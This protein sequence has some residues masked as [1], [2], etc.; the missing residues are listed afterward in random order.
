MAITPPSKDSRL[1]KG[2]SYLF[3]IA[4]TSIIASQSVNVQFK[5]NS[6]SEFEASVATRELN[7]QIFLPCVILIAAILGLPTDAIALAV[8][9][10]LTSKE[11]E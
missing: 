9:K 2:Y 5:I 6:K 11:P 3:A 10:I 4:L 8:G 1:G 7:T